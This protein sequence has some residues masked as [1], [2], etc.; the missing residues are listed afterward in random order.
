MLFKSHIIKISFNRLFS[1]QVTRVNRPEDTRSQWPVYEK[2][3]KS[4]GQVRDYTGIAVMVGII[5]FLSVFSFVFTKLLRSSQR[6]DFLIG[7]GLRNYLGGLHAS[8]MQDESISRGRALRAA[9]T[10]RY[11]GNLLGCT[12]TLDTGPQCS[13]PSSSGGHRLRLEASIHLTHIC[14]EDSISNQSETSQS[15]IYDP[16]PVYADIVSERVTFI[17]RGSEIP[18]P[19]YEDLVF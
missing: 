18:P 2:D 17:N 8:R 12:C 4:R 9:Q 11:S 13:C 5:G 14:V 10:T 16:P 6:E 1:P 7:A 15:L 19:A 3:V